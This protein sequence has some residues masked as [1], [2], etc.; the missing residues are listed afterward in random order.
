MSFRFSLSGIALLQ[1]KISGLSTV[2]LRSI[3]TLRP[4]QSKVA[5]VGRP[6]DERSLK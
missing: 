4:A 3:F 6:N 2:R 5:L 1:K